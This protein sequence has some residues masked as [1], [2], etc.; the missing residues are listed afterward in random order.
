[1]G[2]G[3]RENEAVESRRWLVEGLRR[4][5]V[6]PLATE[7]SAS[8]G[9]TNAPKV[10]SDVE[11]FKEDGKRDIGA[12]LDPS[13][14]EILRD[15]P[16][17][18]YRA[19]ILCASRTSKGREDTDDDVQEEL[20]FG[21]GSERHRKR[22][23]DFVPDTD[24]DEERDEE[25]AESNAVIGVTF[26]IPDSN[27][28]IIELEF[29][30]AR[31]EHVS[32]YWIRKPIH[33]TGKADPG[34]GDRTFEIPLAEGCR[35]EVG[36]SIRHVEDSLY[37][38]AWAANRSDAAPSNRKANEHSLFQSRL[39]CSGL[40]DL[41]PLPGAMDGSDL[42]LSYS[43]SPVY[44]AGHG[45][46]ATEYDGNTKVR[47]ESFPVVKVFKPDMCDVG[48]DFGMMDFARMNGEAEA[49][50]SS[51][52]KQYETWIGNQAMRADS[53]GIDGR[54]DYPD[55]QIRKQLD[56]LERIRHGWNL[57]CSDD[58]VSLCF[59]LAN[60]AMALQR[61]A[62]Q[63]KRRPMDSKRFP[64]ISELAEQSRWRPFQMAFLLASIP[65]L[66]ERK[67]EADVIWMP[68]GGGKTEAYFGLAAFVIL[69]ERLV[70]RK[71]GLKKCKGVKVL[72]RYTLRLLTSQQFQRASSLICALELVR[73][74]HEDE[75][76]SE[77][78]SIGAWLGGAV[79]PNSEAR[80]LAV[81]KGAL[82]KGTP[83]SRFLTTQCPWC[84][85]EMDRKIDDRHLSGY[86][87]DDQ[88]LLPF[89]PDPRCPFGLELSSGNGL[90]IHVVDDQIYSRCPDFIVATVD[91][92][93]RLAWRTDKVERL[94]GLMRKNGEVLRA[95]NPPALFIQD[96]LHLIE[97]P[98]GS[99]YG[100]LESVFESLCEAEGGERP[101]V[102]ASTA[103]TRDYETQIRRLYGRK[104]C[105]VPPAGVSSRD[106]FFASIGKDSEY[107]EYVGFSPAI[108]TSE[109]NQ[110]YPMSV[111]AYL[112]GVM[113]NRGMLNDPWWTNVA[114]FSSRW[115]LA[116]LESS[117]DSKMRMDLRTLRRRTGLDSGLSKDGRTLAA[118]SMNV[119]KEITAVATENV[120]ATLGLL[121]VD[122]GMKDCVDLCYATSMIEVGLDVDR[123]GLMT[124]VGMPKNFS[125]YIQVTGRV[126]RRDTSPAIILVVHNRGNRRDQSYFESF[127][128]NHGRLYASV[129][130]TSVTPT[131]GKAVRRWL[132]TALAML[133]RALGDGK[134][135]YVKEQAEEKAGYA[136][137]L[138]LDWFSS[139]IDD[140]EDEE[141]FRSCL[142]TEYARL[143]NILRHAPDGIQWS[144]RDGGCQFLHGYG[145]ELSAE[146]RNEAHWD[147]LQSM[148][149]VEG[150][151]GF[152]PVVRSLRPVCSIQ[153]HEEEEDDE[154]W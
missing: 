127:V 120:G 103:T 75:F 117:V 6:G 145:E 64:K 12:L 119:R 57:V 100:G 71:K 23:D 19:G 34:A 28:P 109:D 134:P 62:V 47:T 3:Q 136:R 138:L 76:G 31:Y 87:L 151:A 38:T 63:S 90:P 37:C 54:S 40:R 9:Y 123:L 5:L 148:R 41:M 133:I 126:G 42:S 39:I 107:K 135:G 8:L 112:A 14:E 93:V 29:S 137:Q 106:N 82:S 142:D 97:G 45:C 72:M 99:L 88:R 141:R 116:Q 118:R 153:S 67:T 22:K 16:L 30:A 24:D 131:A 53:M 20:D 10:V 113:R 125:Q 143:M 18:T 35:A 15:P 7:D 94:F 43:D 74:A 61:A 2:T 4:H 144:V 13:G 36:L 27:P 85:A 128:Q 59:R 104:A 66:L 139:T 152:G 83:V 150:D 33:W 110:R 92:T 32:R 146:Q 105:L 21:E 111:I 51:L 1:M 81:L 26:R 55:R 101:Y 115:T 77:P 60:E 154:V 86:M 56:F 98:L 96:E 129:E 102:V 65:A 124:V 140:P 130:A 50:V 11:G 108:G 69:H 89:C 114:F 80:A 149:T 17:N 122:N 79:T 132:S 44:V 52:V 70:L 73:R 147:I 46:A 68:T 95:T 121:G 78:V 84:G 25:Q 58:D 48:A 49:A 91:K